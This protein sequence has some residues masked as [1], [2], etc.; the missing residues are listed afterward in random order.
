MIGAS[1][2]GGATHRV[3]AGS[4]GPRTFPTTAAAAAV[5]GDGFAYGPYVQLMASTALAEAALVTALTA[6]SDGGIDV[7]GMTIQLATGAAGAE[8]VVGE[9]TYTHPAAAAGTPGLVLATPVL[10]PASTRL[11]ARVRAHLNVTAG[12][13]TAKTSVT[14]TPLSTLETF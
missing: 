2:S 13:V 1:T 12:Y 3:K 11:A 4:L 9:F 10:L 14:V 7:G 8:V 5:N 6:W